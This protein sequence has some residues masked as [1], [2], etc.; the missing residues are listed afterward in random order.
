MLYLGTWFCASCSVNVRL[1]SFS[2]PKYATHALTGCHCNIRCG[3]CRF[4]LFSPCKG[5]KG[6]KTTE[7]AVVAA[8]E[9]GDGVAVVMVVVVVEVEEDTVVEVAT[10]VVEVS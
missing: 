9:A 5:A 1:R 3:L 4:Q 6:L 10:G 7:V 2:Q 8:I